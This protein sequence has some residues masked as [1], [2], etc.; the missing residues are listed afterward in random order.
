MKQCVDEMP[1]YH[2]SDI[3]ISADLSSRDKYYESFLEKSVI[4]LDQGRFHDC[5]VLFVKFLNWS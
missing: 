4:L 5:H 1:N 3:T 2:N